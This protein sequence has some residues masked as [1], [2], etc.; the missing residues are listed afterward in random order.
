MFDCLEQLCALWDSSLTAENRKD[1]ERT[2]ITF[3]K[4]ISPEEYTTYAK[5]LHSFQLQ[6]LE[7]RGKSLSLVGSSNNTCALIVNY[8]KVKCN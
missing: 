8:L 4:L 2:Q 5:D 1:L 7:S 3:A 6:S